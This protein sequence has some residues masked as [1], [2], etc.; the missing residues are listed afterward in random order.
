LANSQQDLKPKM[1]VFS[2]PLTVE[3]E[4]KA[5]WQQV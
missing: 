4:T 5:V 3:Y 2:A 1:L